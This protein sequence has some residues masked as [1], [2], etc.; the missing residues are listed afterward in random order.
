MFFF[1]HFR[2]SSSSKGRRRHLPGCFFSCI[3]TRL[4]LFF[5]LLPFFSHLHLLLLLFPFM[6][7]PLPHSRPSC[8][9]IIFFLPFFLFEARP[10]LLTFCFC[11]FFFFF[12]FEQ[13][14][15]FRH[16]NRSLPRWGSFAI[17]FFFFFVSKF[18]NIQ[19]TILFTFR[20]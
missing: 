5:L 15:K 18:I 6:C 11:F 1:F 14:L 19:N 2:F 13:I 9:Y 16:A 10:I 12:F 8:L 20:A 4:L 17:V 3:P 7:L